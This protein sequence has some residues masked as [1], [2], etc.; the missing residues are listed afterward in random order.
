[1][2]TSAKHAA[3]SSVLSKLAGIGITA[4]VVA[5]NFTSSPA[6]ATD[7]FYLC[8]DGLPTIST[9]P[10]TTYAISSAKG[11]LSQGSGCSANVVI[12]R[13]AKIIGFDAFRNS[14]IV[15]ITIPDTVTEIG[16]NAFDNALLL[17]Q[18]TFTGVSTL[19]KIGNRAFF[20]DL[21]AEPKLTSIN[22]PA[23]VESIGDSAFKNTELREINFHSESLLETIGD[24][25]FSWSALEEIRIPKN[26]V[27][28]GNNAFQMA[29]NLTNVVFA[30]DS[31]LTAIEDYT[32]WDASALSEITIPK[33]VVSIGT[34]SFAAA[35]SLTVVNFEP[36]ST[37]LSIGPSAFDGATALRTIALPTSLT[38]IGV[39]AF[40]N[41]SSLES[42]NIPSGVTSIKNNTFDGASSLESVTL[43]GALTSIEEEAF[44]NASK[45][46]NITIPDSVTSIAEYAFYGTHSS[47]FS[48]SFKDTSL[49]SGSNY[50][51]VGDKVW[52]SA[53][54][55]HLSNSVR[56][57]GNQSVTPEE[58]VYRLTK[59]PN[60]RT[61]SVDPQSLLGYEDLSAAEQSGWYEDIGFDT[62]NPYLFS[63]RAFLCVPNGSGNLR[64]P[65]N[66]KVS[67]AGRDRVQNG[68]TSANLRALFRRTSEE[69]FGSQAYSTRSVVGT[70]ISP[71]SPQ[72][73][74][75][76]DMPDTVVDQNS[77][78][79]GVGISKVSGTC[80][81]P[82]DTFQAL[83]IMQSSSGTAVTSKSFDV[84]DELWVEV[85][86]G[87]VRSVVNSV[88]VTIGVTGGGP[89]TLP[90]F[91]PNSF[92]AALWGLTTIGSAS[93]P[94][95]GDQ[96]FD[97]S[98][99]VNPK[100]EQPIVKPIS[101]TKSAEIRGF[102]GDSSKA[103]ASLRISV[104][105]LLSS[106]R[107]V[108]S[109]ECTGY[110]SGRAPSRWDTLLANRRAKVACDLVKQRYP[111]AK[112]KVIEKP[113]VGV[114]SKFR[115]VRIKI[116]G[117]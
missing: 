66:Q 43:P 15:S 11:E 64:K 113:A 60:D 81:T 68:T 27:S 3:K 90:S 2:G 33:K 12:S 61:T 71:S 85:A 49:Q 51:D 109:V 89:V 115:S 65:T 97:T 7:N 28:I 46:S 35:T 70:I 84:P 79:F 8:A 14:S 20:A 104:S 34:Y 22:I 108:S 116:V 93:L 103:P 101:K 48:S 19:E 5:S 4:L 107:Q 39:G 24:E 53:F 56:A 31:E 32:F 110:T 36:Q 80:S 58:Y 30:P 59:T 13:D 83:N 18:V 72:L 82:G 57:S 77:L 69:L 117:F 41:A 98:P 44:Y 62:N 38:S 25:A 92:N 55:R 10:A 86:A 105:K 75:G 21:S 91:S 54:E 94:G 99:I 23:S 78:P 47:L 95:G 111:S 50:A 16:N 100:P 76:P 26:V 96:S 74:D 112:V 9:D 88:G 106:Y 87:D 73:L 45:L 114:G 52:A 40:A 17:Q 67:Y 1:M 42:I 102:S 63:W 37:L 29:T 6:R